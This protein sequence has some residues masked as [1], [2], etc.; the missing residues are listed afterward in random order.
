MNKVRALV[1]K[2]KK[3]LQEEGF[4]LDLTYVTRNIIAMGFPSSGLEGLYRNKASDV[5]S[6]F[7]TKHGSGVWV[8]NLCSER[9]YEPSLFEGQVSRYPFDDHNP[10]PLSIIEPFCKEA[11]AWL[12]KDDDNVV[13]IHCKAGKGRTGV[14][15]AALLLYMGSWPTARDALKFYGQMRTHNSK[16]VT[17]PSQVR[18][19]EKINNC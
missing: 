15:I 2:K 17:I 6:F 18:K 1:S 5:V 10:P 3:R 12:A 11:S 16:G 14:M 19:L 8:F 7:K 9:S 4:D 13:A